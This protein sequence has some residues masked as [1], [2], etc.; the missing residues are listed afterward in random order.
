MAAIALSAAY[1][2]SKACGTNLELRCLTIDS[3]QQTA[4][5]VLEMKD[6]TGFLG[7]VVVVDAQAA[8]SVVTKLN[9]DRKPFTTTLNYATIVAANATGEVGVASHIATVVGAGNFISGT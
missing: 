8:S 3:K 2:K 4:C 6:G 9:G 1:M 5:V 7:E